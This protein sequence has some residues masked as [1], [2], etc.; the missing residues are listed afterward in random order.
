MGLLSAV[1]DN[2]PLTAAVMGM[3]HL[4][5]YPIDSKL[6]EMT[7]YCVGTGGSILIIGSA[8][9]VVAMGMEKIRFGWYFKKVSFYALLGY[10][11]GVILIFLTR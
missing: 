7:A 1:L 5:Q 10:F 9:G 2:I 11:G 3:Y 8:A 4:A 6:W